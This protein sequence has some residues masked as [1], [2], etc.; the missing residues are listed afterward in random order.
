MTQMSWKLPVM[1][2]AL[3]LGDILNIHNSLM[4]KNLLYAV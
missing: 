3:G 1:T 4:F 2:E